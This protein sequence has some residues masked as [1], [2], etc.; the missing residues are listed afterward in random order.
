VVQIA[1]LILLSSLLLSGCGDGL[2]PP[3]SGDYVKTDSG[4][5]QAQAWGIDFEIR[6]TGGGGAAVQMSGVRNVDPEKTG[7]RRTI[8]M[9][10]YEIVL[11]K[12]PGTPITMT[13]N[14]ESYGT[15]E[16]GD[17]IRI[18]R[19]I[20][21]VNGVVR[22]PESSESDGAE[23]SGSE[24]TAAPVTTDAGEKEGFE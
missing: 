6:N 13:I 19:K 24:E 8:T 7:A 4:F 2:Y 23:D 1:I 22:E 10:Q 20:V 16:I 14:D 12:V 18:A 5:G 11:E 3:T 17:S 21:R 15:V 9:G